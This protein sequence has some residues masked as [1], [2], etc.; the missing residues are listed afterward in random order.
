MKAIFFKLTNKL[1]GTADTMAEEFLAT[2]KRDEGVSVELKVVNNIRLHRK[3]FALMKF[4][5]DNWEPPEEL[6]EGIPVQR[7]FD[8]F[9]KSLIIAAGFYTPYYDHEGNVHL[10]AHSLSFPKCEDE[11]KNR[12]YNAVLTATW[13]FID[14]QKLISEEERERICLEL[15]RYD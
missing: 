15:L 10:K 2:L 12:I 1:L 8:E 3:L 9:R 6:Y 14:A 11:K 13:A 4:A 5:F 7:D